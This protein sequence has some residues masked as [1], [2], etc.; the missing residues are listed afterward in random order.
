MTSL[1]PGR[2]MPP[3]AELNEQYFERYGLLA[4]RLCDGR[5]VCNIE[6][7]GG[8]AGMPVAP[9]WG[10]PTGGRFLLAL[11][12]VLRMMA[13]PDEL[14]APMAPA[15]TR[16]YK[17]LTPATQVLDDGTR[18]TPWLTRIA[19]L[20]ENQYLGTTAQDQNTLTIPIETIQHALTVYIQEL[21]PDEPAPI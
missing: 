17:A 3:Y 10:E 19:R 21:Y 20:F 6:V 8:L 13:R 12:I 1:D 16:C 11:S 14:T 18:V 7:V 2:H 9:A 5:T 15:F 4:E